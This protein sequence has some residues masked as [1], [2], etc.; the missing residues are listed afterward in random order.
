MAPPLL[1]LQDIHLTFGG[2]PLLEG[3]ELSIGERERVCLVG[4]N[5]SGKSTLLQI[6]AGT[7]EGERGGHGWGR[8]GRALRA[9]RRDDPLSVAGAGPVRLRHNARLRGSG[10]GAR[11]RSASPALPAG[12]APAPL[13]GAGPGARRRPASPALPAGAARPH[14]RGRP[15]A[16]VRRRGAPRRARARA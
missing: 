16:L 9:A 1:T 3:A 7:G 15:R 4:R 11:R 13:R 8:S 2:T 10:T 5:G 12:P 6:A 14:R